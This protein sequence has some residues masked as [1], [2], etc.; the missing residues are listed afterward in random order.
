MKKLMVLATLFS[1]PMIALAGRTKEYKNV[2]YGFR[3]SYPKE[4]RLTE[5]TECYRGG[6]FCLEL[7]YPLPKNFDGVGM[8]ARAI[9]KKVCVSISPDTEEE[10]DRLIP[11]Q[12]EVEKSTV[13]TSGAGPVEYWLIYGTITGPVNG[14]YFR[15]KNHIF[16]FDMETIDFPSLVL[17]KI[18]NSFGPL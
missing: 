5:N 8:E 15:Y 7:A 6:E 11:K 9:E 12:F 17:E 2:E 16:A 14:S 1:F 18:L 4:M 13:S 10:W 3:F